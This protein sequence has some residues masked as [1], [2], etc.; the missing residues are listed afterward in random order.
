LN[1]NTTSKKTG[2]I[3]KSKAIQALSKSTKLT[4]S[5]RNEYDQKP[6]VGSELIDNDIE[7]VEDLDDQEDEHNIE[8]EHD[9]DNNE[10]D[11]QFEEEFDEQALEELEEDTSKHK[12]ATKV[13]HRRRHSARLSV[14][15]NRSDLDFGYKLRKNSTSNLSVESNSNHSPSVPKKKARLSTET[16]TYSSSIQPSTSSSATDNTNTASN[17]CIF[18]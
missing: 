5:P 10:E 7:L 12:R 6:S 2:R 8:E 9:V 15:S 4:K 13:S 14:S 17:K 16:A 18:F 11:V 1:L 3:A